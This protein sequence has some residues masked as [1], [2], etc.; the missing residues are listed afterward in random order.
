MIVN[1]MFEIWE[2]PKEVIQ[3]DIGRIYESGPLETIY[4]R[5]LK[6]QLGQASNLK[7]SRSS[8]AIL[9]QQ[10]AKLVSR[11][12]NLGHGSPALDLAPPSPIP[13]RD[14]GTSLFFSPSRRIEVFKQLVQR[15]SGR[16]SAAMVVDQCRDI[17]CIPSLEEREHRVEALYHQWAQCPGSESEIE[18]GYLLADA[19]RDLAFD[20]EGKAPVLD[21]LLDRVLE[22]LHDSVRAIFPL[23][24]VPPPSPPPYLADLIAAM[25]TSTLKKPQHVRTIEELEAEIQAMAVQE[26]VA[27][28]SG[29]MAKPSKDSVLAFEGVAKWIDGSVGGVQR[30][31]G[32]DLR[33]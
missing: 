13:S 4:M 22:M 23:R 8:T 6:T 9:T 7:P 1:T 15:A 12:P 10:V 29:M 30:A 2:V 16:R 25:S 17:W 19:V 26:Y 28:A 18:V 33:G 5:D 31:W 27:S 24:P 14:G 3:R 11:F 32:S 20:L 21:E